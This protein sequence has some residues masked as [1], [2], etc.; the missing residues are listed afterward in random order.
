MEKERKTIKE[1]SIKKKILPAIVVFV[2][3]LCALFFFY[4][5]FRKNQEMKSRN[6]KNLSEIRHSFDGFLVAESKMLKLGLVNLMKC[7]V[8]K[9]LFLEKDRAKLYE[10][11]R[12]FFEEQKNLAGITHWIF[13]EPDGSVFL[14][15]HKPESFGMPNQKRSTF[16]R[17]EET[18]SWGTGLELGLFGFVQRAVHPYYQNGQLIGYMELGEDITLILEGMKKETKS[19]FALVAFKHSVDHENWR[20][21]VEDSKARDNYNDMRDFVILGSTNQE[22]INA[23][24]KCFSESALKSLSENGEILNRIE[25]NEKNYVCGAF[26]LTDAKN[27]KSGAIVVATDITSEMKALNRARFNIFL[28]SIGATI[29]IYLILMGLVNRKVIYPLRKLT[30]TAREINEKNLERKIIVGDR[31]EIGLLAEA[32]NDMTAKIGNYQ[33]RLNKEKEWLKKQVEEKTSELKNRVSKLEDTKKAMVSILEDVEESRKQI[34]LEK[35]RYKIERDRSEGI[36]RYLQS[37]GEGV[38]VTNENKLLT[39]INLT[40]AKT[41]CQDQCHLLIGKEYSNFFVF[42]AKKEGRE[43]Q[44]EPLEEVRQKR[45]VYHLPHDCFLVIRDKK[46]P[47]VGSVG[48]IIKNNELIGIVTVFQDI[49]ERYKI[50][51]EKDNFL[52][53]AAHQLRTPLTGIRWTIESLLDGDAGKINEQAREWLRQILENNQR[54]ISL[55]NDLLD[56]SRINMGK[57]KEEPVLINVCKTVKE[58]VDSLMGLAKERQVAVS[59]ESVC[60]IN[61]EIKSGPK[62]LFHSLENLISNAI[63][64]TPPGGSVKVGVEHKENKIII[65]VADN[66]IGIPASDHSKVF[67]KFF[68]SANAMLKETEGSGLGLNVVKSF[69]DESGGKIWFESR[70]NEGTTFFLELPVE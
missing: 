40:A 12:P 42:V 36:L 70:E 51:K 67:N 7:D 31:D 29:A 52:S 62:N 58:A 57:S 4:D 64:Y 21:F 5:F 30:F 28:L 34:E 60:K 33:K 17:A 55:V 61:P 13:Y 3:F 45:E 50:E 47:I 68:R 19:D 10:H 41:I 56:V 27:E 18:K 1:T 15:M 25:F 69:V 66:G 26:L 46:I 44:I 14:R 22:L 6:T 53:I 63:K 39:F 43:I 38:V 16:L 54:L 24:N 37:I 9:K 20:N 48:P 23:E 2:I 32:F 35:S 59:Y 65:S 49:T 8:I 11:A